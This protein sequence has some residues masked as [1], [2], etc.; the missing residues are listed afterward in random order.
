MCND[1]LAGRLAT[2]LKTLP[3]GDVLVTFGL[4]SPDQALEALESTWGDAYVY[5]G[6]LTGLTHQ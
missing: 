5:T 6:R 4:L 2:V 1:R 3:D